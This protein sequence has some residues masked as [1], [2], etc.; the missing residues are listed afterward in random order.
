ME[1]PSIVTHTLTATETPSEQPNRLRPFVHPVGAG[2]RA[3]R[4]LDQ[5]EAREAMEAILS[6]AFAPATLGAF[7]L[8]LRMKGETAAE[9]GACLE[10]VRA[11]AV[12]ALPEPV[13][14]LLD[15]SGNYDGRLRTPHLS[16]AAALSVAAEGVPVLLHAGSDVPTKRGVTA[17]HVVG[18][19]GV[20]W[21]L[22]PEAVARVIRAFGMGFL[23]QCRHSPGL[24][25]LLPF[26]HQLGVRTVLN[27][28]EPLVNPLS[29]VCHAG[30]MF[31]RAAGR[32][33]AEAL[34]AAQPWVRRA[35]FVQGIEG[36]EEA[37]PGRPW[38]TELRDGAISEQA[39]DARALGLSVAFGDLD[40]SAVDPK[41]SA[42]LCLTVL[43][44]GGP[45]WA[46]EVVLLTAAVWL[47][48]A[49]RE[50]DVGAGV[51][52]AAT[53]LDSGRARR[54]LDDWRGASTAR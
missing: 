2:P 16:L 39:L 21:D 27:M 17:A 25:P 44:G 50:P 53:A 46:R 43:A 12:C 42:A 23:H 33:L 3:S 29:A 24:S 26:R 10:A 45:I 18:A 6:G 4:D 35:V 14:G 51:C 40:R 8:G 31:H 32:R 37:C 19:L 54:L 36:S 22:S 52:R 20:P 49:G 5:T 48:A 11:H 1:V 9:L 38:L 34:Q 30:G 47:Y 13:P 7:L 15:V 41:E 28:I